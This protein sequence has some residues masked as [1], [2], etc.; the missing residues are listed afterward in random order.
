MAKVTL[1]GIDLAKNIFQLHGTDEAGKVV[2]K[3]KIYRDE[4]MSYIRN[5]PDC[6]IA[7]EACGGSSYFA[8]EFKKMGHAVRLIS[9][10]FVKPFVKTNK[11]DANDAEA[12]VIAARQP[13]MRF[14]PANTLEEQDIQSIHRFRSLLVSERTALVNHIRGVLT[15]YG[16]TAPK[17][18]A[19][20]R[21]LL[22]SIKDDADNKK[23]Q[24]TVIIKEQCDEYG[25]ALKH[26]DECIKKCDI[27][28][29]AIA[30]THPLCQ[31]LM[32]VPGVGEITATIMLTVLSDPS[33]FKNG[34]HFAASLGLVPRQHSSGGKQK[35]YGISKRGDKYIRSLLVHG[36]RSVASRLGTKTDKR[37]LWAKKLYERRGYNKTAVAIANKNARVLWAL[38][39]NNTKYNKDYK[40]AV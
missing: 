23:H 40:P 4:L 20:L 34:R 36:G 6:T 14:V 2:V 37:S 33:L 8:R 21:T 5:T 31:K 29:E 12:I 15:E 38:A 16:I 22:A 10:Q 1:L 7:M 17:G 19:M 24:I 30:N 35:L 27:K 28:I 3:K 13:E 25:E 11:T 39:A 9:P 32:T 18:I 26:K